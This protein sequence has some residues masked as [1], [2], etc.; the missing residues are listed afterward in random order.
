MSGN[1]ERKKQKRRLRF[2]G[3]LIGICNGFLGGGG[4]MIAVPLLASGL[5]MPQKIAH[6]TAIFLILPLSA[7]SGLIYATFGAFP[8]K[9]GVYTAAG[10][11]LGGLVGALML[12][13]VPEKLVFWIF[14]AAMALSGA[15]LLFG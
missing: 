3:A 7:V 14:T 11:V 6:A 4:G 13:K 8:G 9:R 10:V 5:E 12:K 15:Y 1:S 2:F